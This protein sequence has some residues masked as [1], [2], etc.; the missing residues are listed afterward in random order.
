MGRRSLSVS[1]L[2]AFTAVSLTVQAGQLE[3]PGPV[4]STMQTAIRAA[5]L[6][7]TINVPGLY[8]LEEDIVAGG[9]GITISAANVTLDLRGHSL[10]GGTG[11]GIVALAGMQNLAVRNGTVSGWS[12]DGVDLSQALNSQV[13][14][15]RAQGN[16]EDG[17]RIGGGSL[18]DRCSLRT[19]VGDGIELAGAATVVSRCTSTLNGGSGINVAA[20]TSSISHCAAH[21]NGASGIAGNAF[22]AN[23]T[24]ST[25][26][27]NNDDGISLAG[28]AVVSRCTAYANGDAAGDDGISVGTGSTV[29]DCTADLNAEDGIQV[30]TDCYVAR[31]NANANGVIDGAGIHVTSG[32]NRIEANNATDN[33]RGFDVDLANNL[34]IRNSA[35][36]NAT[37]YD[38]VA[39]NTVGPT[40]TSA[41]IA[42]SSN[43]HANYDY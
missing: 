6:P 34:I 35:G 42:A 10:H 13:V 14:D 40:V 33:D 11:D 8:V 28:G 9:G 4:G 20:G 38:I 32:G 39:G 16:G 18:V 12:G 43:P 21:D 19:N 30:S 26:R 15:L 3:P 41:G 2:L 24:D 1:W 23:V 37:E 25:V 29:T 17:I 7:L 5:D 22:G 27:D 31:N 36:A